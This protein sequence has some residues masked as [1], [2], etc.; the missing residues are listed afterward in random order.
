VL[1]TSS[2]RLSSAL[3]DRLAALGGLARAQVRL[4][5][6]DLWGLPAVG[7]AL[8]VALLLAPLHWQ[9]RLSD[10]AFGS[11]IVAAIGVAFLYGRDVDRGH[12]LSLTTPTSPHALLLL[13]LGLLAVYELVIN[14]AGAG[15]FALAHSAI[16]P[17][18]FL[19]YW[20]AP[21]CC[22]M[23]ISLLVA[24]A[25]HPLVAALVSV[26]LWLFRALGHLAVVQSSPLAAYD[27]FWHQGALPWLVAAL[28]VGLTL[29]LLDRRERM[30]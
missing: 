20:L 1:P 18:W 3:I 28:A 22:L 13:R 4:V 10:A 5:R 7:L 11:A 27:R 25:L 8:V 21:L 6:G 12:E 14:V 15:L 26:A 24:S 23:A 29:L 16:T 17:G 30:A 2:R 9:E 19:A